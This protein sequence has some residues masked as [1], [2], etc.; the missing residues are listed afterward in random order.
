MFLRKR[1][2]RSQTRWLVGAMSAALLLTACGDDGGDTDTD[3][4]AEE[5]ETGEDEEAGGS[6]VGEGRAINIGWIPWEEDIAVTNLWQV[7]LE[8]NGFEVTQ[9]QADV[10][11]VFDGVATGELDLFFDAWLPS[12]HSDY[13]EQYGD[14]VE[15]LGAWLP[16]A[17]LTW[18]VPSYVDV[19]SIADLADNAEM[20]DSRIIGI[21]PGSGLARISEEEVMPAYGLDDWEHVTGSTAAMLTE[22]EAA[23]GNEEPIVVTLWEPHPAYGNFDLKN[24]EDPEGALGEPDEIRTLARDGFSDEFPEV[25]AALGNMEFDAGTLAEL[26]VEVLGDEGNEL[27]AARSWLE[28]NRDY[29]AAWLEG[30]DLSI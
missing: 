29:V 22:L 12:T 21:E 20:F 27:E 3:T 14:Q 5:T 28:A 6:D 7:I 4:D 10:A 11:P 8:D 15:D 26:E 19:D 30:T 23:I 13:W 2:A 16:E 25:A 9:T 17:P 1:L 18:V 24:L